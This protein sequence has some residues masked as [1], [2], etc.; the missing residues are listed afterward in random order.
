MSLVSYVLGARVIE[1]HFTLNRTMKGTDHAFSLEP[2][3][4]QKLVRDIKR[5]QIALG[6][7]VKK[8]YVSEVAPLTKMSKSMYYVG[9]LSAG[10][11]L[12]LNHVDF[13]SPGVGIS[14][15]LLSRFIGKKLITDVNAE[16]LLENEHFSENS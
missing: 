4:M 14:P 7:G 2:Q 3:G 8:T 15:A 5:T 10:T 9:N 11:T 12:D 13:R 16:Q 1:K 6:D